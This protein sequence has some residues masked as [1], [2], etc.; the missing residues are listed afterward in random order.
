M[1]YKLQDGKLVLLGPRVKVNDAWIEPTAEWCAANGWKEIVEGTPACPSTCPLIATCTSA[2]SGTCPQGKIAVSAATPYTDGTDAITHNTVFAD[3]ADADAK[4]I[5]A[6]I[7]SGDLSAMNTD[8]KRNA[9]I[10]KLAQFIMK[11]SVMVMMCL[12]VQG[13]I[14]TA[15][16]GDLSDDAQV[17]TGVDMSDLG[18]VKTNKNGIINTDVKIGSDENV[19]LHTNGVIDAYGLVC[20]SI[21]TDGSIMAG[22]SGVVVDV[23]A[24]N[25]DSDNLPVAH[26]LT[27]K[28]DASRVVPIT[29]TINGKTLDQDITIQEMT[30]NAVIK[31]NGVLKTMDGTTITA[32]DVGAMSS[33][34]TAP[35]ASVNS[36]TGDVTLDADDVGAYPASSGNTLATQVNTIGAHLNAEDA[37]F[38]ST[39][40]DSVVHIPEAYV[41]I[42]VTDA[43]TGVNNWITIWR[44]MTRWNAFTG[45]DFDW[46]NW[47]GFFSFKTNVTA[48]LSMKADRAWGVYESD[49]GA[50]NPDGILQIS[51]PEIYI[52]KGMAYQRTLTTDGAIWILECNSGHAVI[53]GDTNGVFRISD[54][55]GNVHFEIVKGDQQEMGADASG[56]SVSAGNIVTVNYSVEADS[57]PTLEVSLDLSTWK[58]END[59]DCYHTVAWSGSSGAYVATL[60]PK[61]SYPKAFVRA[62]YMAGA[63]TY[64]KNNQPVQMDYIVIGGVKYRLGVGTNLTDNTM[65]LQL[66]R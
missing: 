59:S 37:H 66:T 28:A 51:T 52:A 62:T 13:G 49:S 14:T 19:V 61:A 10:R 15:L 12:Q 24:Y 53:N 45:L 23:I 55:E 4:A 29:R 5:A 31:T 3:V 26:Y 50:Y 22:Y 32:S 42:N 40:Y 44:E 65:F 2:N 64:I 47:D 54:S 58:S 39:N 18:Y 38:V 46:D 27:K 30:D 48:E 8:N 7:T 9:I 36:Q 60:T 17:V 63:E 16:K 34:Y 25:K 35:V 11:T 1:Y 41:E 57:H 56:I 33:S 21:Y 20:D 6:S 43:N